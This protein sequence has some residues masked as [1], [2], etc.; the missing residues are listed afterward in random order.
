MPAETHCFRPRCGAFHAIFIDFMFRRFMKTKKTKTL[1]ISTLAGGVL[2][3][4]ALLQLFWG[5]NL[6]QCGDV[7]SNPGPPKTPKT[8]QTRLD[9][10]SSSKGSPNKSMGLGSPDPSLKDVV[11]Q[12]T[13]ME[14]RLNTKIES[15]DSKMDE[16]LELLREELGAAYVKLQEEVKELRG[17]VE[18]LKEE[19]KDLRRR[20]DTLEAKSDDLEN[21]SRRNNVLFYGLKREDCEKEPGGCEQVVQ[22]FLHDTLGFEEAVTFDRVHRTSLKPDAPMIARCAFYRDRVRILGG[23]SGLKGTNIF[24][25]EDFSERVRGVRS[26]LLPHLKEAKKA[27]KK[28]TMI[29]DHLLIEG[30]KFKLAADGS[31]IVEVVS[32]RR[33]E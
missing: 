30:K 5:D 10:A 2:V 20:L 7:E 6:Q 12:L 33:T 24:L 23:K 4:L 25:G 22:N 3:A 1:R 32:D 26:N 21:R 9:S 19:N 29:Y 14:S 28:A 8:V 18:G 15:M 31:N 17:E 16:R 27:E 11:E 13:S